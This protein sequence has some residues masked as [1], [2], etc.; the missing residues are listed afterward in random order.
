MARST[1]RA[2]PSRLAHDP[3]PGDRRC[4]LR[5]TRNESSLPSGQMSSTCRRWG[6][7]TSSPSWAAPAS[8]R[9]GSCRGCSAGCPQKS[10]PSTCSGTRRSAPSAP[11][12]TRATGR[13]A[14]AGVPG[15]HRAVRRARQAP[16][17]SWGW[18]AASRGRATS[19]SFGTM[20]SPVAT[21]SPAGGTIRNGFD[22]LVYQPEF[23]G[24]RE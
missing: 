13:R 20:S 19:T 7:P 16:S 21:R 6:S 22:G 24:G 18:R 2:S 23:Q 8:R 15:W 5:P 1:D 11:P 9:P 17:P 3:R 4:H 12:T 14:T 10:A